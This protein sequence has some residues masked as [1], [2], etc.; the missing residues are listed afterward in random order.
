MNKSSYP[1]DPWDRPSMPVVDLSRWVQGMRDIY[2]LKNKGLID[3]KA[4]EFVTKDWD[5]MD[6]FRFKNWMRFYEQH[7]QE[8][9]VTA[10]LALQSTL[11]M[12]VPPV[13]HSISPQLEKRQELKDR[14]RSLLSRLD[15]AEKIL[16]KNPDLQIELQQQGLDVR[17]LLST[18]HWLKEEIQT[19][20]IRRSHDLMDDFIIKCANR[21]IAKGDREIAKIALRVLTTSEESL[22]QRDAVN[23]ANL[24]AEKIAEVAPLL[25][26]FADQHIGFLYAGEALEAAAQVA[27]QTAL[28]N[29]DMGVVKLN[30][31]DTV[32]GGQP[33]APSGETVAPKLLGMPDAPEGEG[34]APEGE[35]NK[36]SESA[37]KEFLANISGKKNTSK[38]QDSQKADDELEVTA[39]FEVFAQEAAVLPQQADVPPAAPVVPGGVP[40]APE[41]LNKK[42]I[43]DGIGPE[44]VGSMAINIDDNFDRA[45]KNIKITD[46]IVRLEGVAKLFKNREVSRQLSI[47][48]LMMDSVGV[49]PF[50]PSMAEAMQKSLEAN[51]YCQTRVEDI[52]SKL[53]GIVQT[54]MSQSVEDQVI[55]EPTEKAIQDRLQE[56][57]SAE[58]AR[59]EKRR[60][61]SL[62]EAAKPD[63][64]LAATPAAQQLQQEVPQP[65]AAPAQQPAQSPV[66]PVG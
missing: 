43:N 8:K 34:E 65:P 57:E 13:S 56:E 60:K 28:P 36:D 14:I 10:Q 6:K 48:D 18:L 11:P 55:M 58:K 66:P 47:I 33:L 4:F 39:S 61:E 23:Q 41:E 19:A 42:N 27:Q 53:R 59:K 38:L 22:I 31:V 35:D 21:L 30:P 15:A 5:E 52:L 50:F 62:E 29:N 1:Q 54:P 63:V 17:K 64:P 24:M 26:R 20:P 25:K 3:S 32:G 9:Y 16:G 49:A 7:G 12:F 44:P 45:L 51:Q 37:L 2:A 46:V 40:I